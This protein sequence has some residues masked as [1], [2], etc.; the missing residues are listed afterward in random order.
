MFY[1]HL[2]PAKSLT[3]SLFSNLATLS[4]YTTVVVSW[5]SY[6]MKQSSRLSVTRG[7]STRFNNNEILVG[8]G[9]T[10]GE[11]RQWAR[12]MLVQL[13]TDCANLIVHATVPEDAFSPRASF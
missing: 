3:S 8:Q 10:V 13:L 4:K 12:P 11:P 1:G 7:S 9:E 5:Y 6:R 2:R